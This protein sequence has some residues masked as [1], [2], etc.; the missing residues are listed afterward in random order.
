MTHLDILK[1]WARRLL[2]W[3]VVGLVAFLIVQ[4]RH[5]TAGRMAGRQA[6][7][8]AV[9]LSDGSRLE[10][11]AAPE[12][13]V[14]LNFWATWCAP[15]R[16]EAPELSHIHRELAEAGRGR[17]VG[18]SVEQGPLDETRQ[19]ADRLGM[20]YPIGVATP[21]LLKQYAV[22]VLPTT[23]V[24]GPDGRVLESFVGAVTAEQLRAT[25]P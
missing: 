20:R 11:G 14:V 21:D 2:P 8:T 16:A 13:V 12:D 25:F 5:G 6:P 17:V 10:L 24:I 3:A 18:I 9:E 7:D 22:E 4:N 19:A 15:C 23:Y 1:R